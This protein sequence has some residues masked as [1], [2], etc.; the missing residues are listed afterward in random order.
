MMPLT[1]SSLSHSVIASST[2]SI[3]AY[4]PFEAP[5]ARGREG[6]GIGAVARNQPNSPD[7]RGI[8]VRP[9]RATPP[10]AM[11]CFIRFVYIGSL[12]QCGSTRP[13]E[14]PMLSHGRRLY[15]HP[16]C[17]GQT[18]SGRLAL[19][20]QGI[21]VGRSSVR[22]FAAD[23][24][25]FRRLGSRHAPSMRFFPLS[26]PSHLDLFQSYV[27]AHMALGGPSNS[28]CC[29]MDFHHTLH[30]DCSSVEGFRYPWDLAPGLSLP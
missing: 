17:A 24:P 7:S 22:G 29:R 3:G 14:L 1:S 30:G 20:P 15:L 4:L 2:K 26:P 18:A 12:L 5:P 11:S 27:V 6:L 16:L 9:I 23:C 8:S 13:G 19:L 28:I 10:P 25:L 21:V